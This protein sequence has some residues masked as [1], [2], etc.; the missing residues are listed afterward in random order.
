MITLSR[1]LR[2]A[3]DAAYDAAREQ[4]RSC[5]GASD[6]DRAAARALYDAL[7]GACVAAML[8]PRHPY[9]IFDPS[10]TDRGCRRPDDGDQGDETADG[11]SAWAIRFF[12]AVQ[13]GA[14]GTKRPPVV[15]GPC[16]G[17]DLG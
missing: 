12:A 13:H 10:N 5:A 2:Q 1:R 6:A 14:A 7:T 3:Y 8:W 17:P 11:M 9:G 15:A 16:G 4:R